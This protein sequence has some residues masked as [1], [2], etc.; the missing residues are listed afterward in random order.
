MILDARS[1]GAGN[2]AVDQDKFQRYC[3]D[4]HWHRRLSSGERVA[5]EVGF[6]FCIHPLNQMSGNKYGG[7]GGAGGSTH[8]SPVKTVPSESVMV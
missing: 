1:M 6:N 8:F 7:G 3:K 5:C 2:A 4:A